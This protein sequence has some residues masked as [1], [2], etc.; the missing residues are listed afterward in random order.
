MTENVR[1]NQGIEAEDEIDR[2]I[3]DFVQSS[4]VINENHWRCAPPHAADHSSPP[5]CQSWTE[6]HWCKFSE[7]VGTR[8]LLLLVELDETAAKHGDGPIAF[9]RLNR[10]RDE[11]ARR[12]I[13][14]GVGNVR[15]GA[16]FGG[17]VTRS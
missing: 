3:L 2:I 4:S 14:I 15:L 9:K 12:R 13:D 7:M 6:P 5:Y 17:F 11:A 8:W 1:M 10:R 16:G